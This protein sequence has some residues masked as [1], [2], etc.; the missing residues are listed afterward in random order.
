M[1][2]ITIKLSLIA[3]LVLAVSCSDN[4][5]NIFGHTVLARSR[6]RNPNALLHLSQVVPADFSKYVAVGNSLTAGFSERG[7]VYGGSRQVFP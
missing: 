4:E 2:T 5:D 7:T 3:L 6:G 1:K